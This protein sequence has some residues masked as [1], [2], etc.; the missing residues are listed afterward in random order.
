[1]ISGITLADVASPDDA[2]DMARCRNEVRSYL[3]HNTNPISPEQQL[4]WYRTT[5]IPGRTRGKMFGYVLREG[6]NPIGY[7]LITERDE[8]MWV[9]GGVD[10][11]YRGKGLGEAVFHFLTEHIHDELGHS[12]AFLDVREDN[13]PAQRLYEKLGYSALGHVNGLIQMIHRKEVQS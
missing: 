4:E 8:L 7:G 9:S 1:M 11:Q 2:L 6:L 5:Y 3:T 12:G 10:Q 13:I